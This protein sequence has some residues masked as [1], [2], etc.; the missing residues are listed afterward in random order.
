MDDTFLPLPNFPGYR[1]S[2]LGNVESSWSRHARPAR[3]TDTW[4]SLKP[5]CRFKYLT[6]NLSKGGRKAAHRIHRLVLGAFVGSCPEGLVACHNDGDPANNAVEN[7]RWDTL[8]ANSEDTLLHGRRS[9]G[10]NSN[11]KLKEGQV[12]QIRR[13][14]GA[15]IP[16]RELAARFGVSPRHVGSIVNRRCWRHLP[17]HV[18]DS[19]MNGSVPFWDDVPAVVEG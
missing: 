14:A 5:V 15:G 10:E 2:R 7:L 17:G 11:S 1:V 9:R 4:L 12:I 8:R 3:M 16:S 19:A 18:G 6:V 13:L